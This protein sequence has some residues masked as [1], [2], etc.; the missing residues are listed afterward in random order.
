MRSKDIARAL[1]HLLAYD[2]IPST[3]Y[4][5]F[6][7]A[8]SCS[9]SA[10]I[11]GSRVSASQRSTRLR[12]IM[13]AV[14][15]PNTSLQA[16]ANAAQAHDMHQHTKKVLAKSAGSA[17]AAALPS[18]PPKRFIAVATDASTVGMR[19]QISLPCLP[20]NT[21]LFVGTL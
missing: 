7:A 13:S 17:A 16:S 14:F 11:F 15:G 1:L 19:S 21:L 10:V 9:C 18:P 6:L 5:Y 2:L 3:S 4:S 8:C 20:M 12:A